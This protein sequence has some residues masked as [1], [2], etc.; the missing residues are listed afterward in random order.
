MAKK[1]R[2]KINDKAWMDTYSDMVTLLMCF[3]VLLFSMSTIDAQKW[4]ILVQGFNPDAETQTQIVLDQEDVT[5]STPAIDDGGDAL[6][7]DSEEVT[8][9]T[10][11]SEPIENFDELYEALQQ[12]VDENNLQ[13][14][15][16]LFEGEDYTYVMFSNNIFFDGDSSVLKSEGKEILDVF[17]SAIGQVSDLVSKIQVLGH[18]NQADPDKPNNVS[19]DRFLSSNRAVEVLIYL[20][21]KNIVDPGVLESI[22]YGQHY[23]IGSFDDP[24]GRAKNRRVELV[25]AQDPAGNVNL[26][27]IYGDIKAAQASGEIDS[28]IIDP[29]V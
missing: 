29:N 11:S 5:E 22:G 27:Q 14:Q 2:E 3:F 10:E 19:T 13:D 16:K 1:P 15:I 18:T 9:N 17:A 12:Y 4:Q 25:I 6:L 8:D 20:Q 21:E 28:Q 23:P 26:E 7:E 24:V